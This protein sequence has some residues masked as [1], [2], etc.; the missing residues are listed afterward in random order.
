MDFLALHAILGHDGI[1]VTAHDGVGS[2]VK[3]FDM[4]H[5]DCRT[6]EEVVGEVVFERWGLLFGGAGCK[7]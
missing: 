1:E 3:S 7:G 5:V 2:G 6:D 4:V